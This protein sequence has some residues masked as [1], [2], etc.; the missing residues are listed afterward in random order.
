MAD[1]NPS[2]VQILKAE[3]LSYDGITRR[4]ISTNYIYGFEIAQSMDTVA[5]AG[6][7][8]IIDT[9]NLLEGMP[10]RGE[11]TLNLV[12]RGT[13]LNTVV[14]IAGIIHKVDDISPAGNSGGLTYA[15]HFV[16]KES[17]KASTKNVMTSFQDMPSQMAYEIFKEYFVEDLGEA[18]YKDQDN[19]KINLP[20][21]TVR[22]P[23]T[24]NGDVKSDPDRHFVLQPANNTT[25][26]II[27]DLKPTE[28]MFFVAAR[29]FNPAT[30][31]QTFRFF[32]T[33][34]GFYWC[35][36]EYFI[37][38]ANNTKG[39]II[40]LF[41]APVVDLDAKNAEAQLKRVET[42]HILSKG[43][44]T[45]TDLYSGAYT[46][47]VVEIDLI[48]K[49]VD[50]KS[51]NY[52]NTEY[53]DMSGSKRSLSD[54]PHTEKFRKDTFTSDNAR[55]FMLFK[56]Y[57]SPGDMVSAQLPD[58]RIP[59]ITS[60]RISYYHHLNN[61]SIIAQ[62]K[63]RLDIRP[64]M[65]ANL[66]VKGM[67][68]VADNFDANQSLSGRYLVQKTQHAQDENGTLQ[69][70]LQLAKFDWSGKQQLSSTTTTDI[71]DEPIVGAR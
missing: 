41:Y 40:D 67:N 11:E 15:I 27:P 7:L 39:K 62:M 44:D 29:A 2:E 31:S 5:Y 70:T 1:F 17:F 10:I 22:Y 47:E 54:N 6:K 18:S 65:I 49:K 4:D 43:I 61:T 50:L 56:N 64:G 33:F 16:S 9:S 46:N 71:P 68:S 8:N 13:D 36:D 24:K 42:L 26:V 52:D 19:D 20:Y 51:F 53:I 30:P 28:A 32:E 21:Q 69:T 63:G 60:N 23:I 3:L 38:K 25:R 37:R 48:K 35:T 57:N 59:E 34:D 58:A 45:S 66:E 14:R 55:R 12:L